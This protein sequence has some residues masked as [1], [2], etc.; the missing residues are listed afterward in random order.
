MHD[1]RLGEE[2]HAVAVR[3]PVREMNHIDLFSVEVDGE[4]LIKGDD[5]PAFLRC[6]LAGVSGPL[7][8]ARQPLADVRVGQDG[9]LG[10]ED[11][12]R[13]GVVAVPVGVEDELQFA[14]THAFERRANLVRQRGEFIV[15]N[16]RAVFTHRRTDIAARPGQHVDIAPNLLGFDFGLREV[17]LRP[18]RP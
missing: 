2:D 13:A 11:R 7:E 16:Q 18:G 9:R 1:V 8:L 15:D 17:P 14:A 4:R 3:V 12:V 5:R 6:G 10:A